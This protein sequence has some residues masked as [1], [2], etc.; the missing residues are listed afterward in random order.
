VDL[1]EHLFR[2]ESVALVPN[3]LC[4]FGASEIAAAFIYLDMSAV[5]SNR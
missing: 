3:I 5:S 1:E 4:G 2:R